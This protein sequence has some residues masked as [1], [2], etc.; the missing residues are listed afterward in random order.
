MHTKKIGRPSLATV[1][2]KILGLVGFLSIMMVVIAIVGL[3]QM[4]G[5]G[6]ELE[7]IADETVPLT[8]NVSKVSMHQLEQAL[9]VEKVLRVGKVD[10]GSSVGE[11]DTLTKDLVALASKVD[12]EILQAEEIARKGID[13]ASTDDQRAKYA[14]VLGQLK[15]I[16][17]EHKAYDDHIQTIINHI[18][19]GDITTAEELAVA[20]E[21][22]QERLNTE[23]VSLTEQLNRFV[24]TSTA[25]AKDHEQHGIVVMGV[26]ATIAI[27]AGVGLAMLI[28]LFGISRPLRAVVAALNRLAQNDTSVE[29]GIR[30]GGEIG[31]LATAFTEFREKTI[32]IQRLQAQAKEEEERIERE[33]R[34]ATMRLADNL[35][36]TVKRVSDGIAVAVHELEETA[37]LMAKNAQQTSTNAG[38]VAAAAEESSTGVQTVASAAEELSASI[39]E[40]SRQVTAA[41]SATGETNE[42][43]R[44]SSDTVNGLASSAS[45]IDDVVKLINDISDQTNLLALNATIEAAR[46]GEAGRGFA[47]V[48]GEVKA[49][50]GQTGQATEDISSQVKEMQSGAANT[51]QAISAVVDAINRINDQISSIASAVE[52]QTAVTAEIARNVSEVAEGSNDITRTINSVSA[53]A[54]DSSAAARQVLSTVENLA[55]QSGLLQQELDT[56]LGNIRAA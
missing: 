31:E 28:A 36:A 29:L 20:L 21:S 33:K 25:T 35:E 32:E 34:E 49:L 55:S 10:A 11:L 13:V 23:L 9:L 16:E 18:R 22:E 1:S 38:T 37:T 8:T 6:K 46:A 27:V 41:L 47:V 48:A 50:A 56:F 51:S 7:E 53:G 24:S 3:T 5:I 45:R 52:E 4:Q 2:A 42:N 43:A 12:T 40:I 30:A 44:K 15:T 26:V 39:A 19:N 54:V 17:T 14:D